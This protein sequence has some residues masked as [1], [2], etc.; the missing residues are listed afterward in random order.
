MDNKNDICATNE[1]EKRGIATSALM[2]SLFHPKYHQYKIGNI[3]NI[4]PPEKR[5]LLMKIDTL[6]FS[7]WE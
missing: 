6:E 7:K 4:V 3:G 5:R 1:E 2:L